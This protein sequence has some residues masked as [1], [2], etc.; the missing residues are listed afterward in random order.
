MLRPTILDYST[1][2]AASLHGGHWDK[3]WLMIESRKGM[4]Q[5]GSE[6]LFKEDDH[7]FQAVDLRVARR[8]PR[9]RRM[10]GMPPQTACQAELR[11][12]KDFL[13]TPTC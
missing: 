13:K 5:T 4:S 9:A 10:L 7:E 12:G 8:M 11:S 1:S 3:R 6:K 2:I